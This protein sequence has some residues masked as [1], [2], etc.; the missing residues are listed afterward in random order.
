MIYLPIAL[1]TA[2]NTVSKKHSVINSTLRSFLVFSPF[3][4][5]PITSTCI[6]I[7]SITLSSN[8]KS[9]VTLLLSSN[10]NYG[11]ILLYH[12]NGIL[13]LACTYLSIKHLQI[14]FTLTRDSYQAILL[15]VF[16]YLMFSYL[17]YDRDKV[18]FESIRI[19][20]KIKRYT[21]S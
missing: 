14:Y 18:N 15:F 10:L 13:H 17:A 2:N 12:I 8:P 19:L 9:Q 5:P 20:C 11:P 1:P 16:F 3:Q 4:S 6:C 7:T 21:L